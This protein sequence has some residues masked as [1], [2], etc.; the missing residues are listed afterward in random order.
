MPD[1][2]RAVAQVNHVQAAVEDRDGRR[3]LTQL[4]ADSTL[5]PGHAADAPL[6][7]ERQRASGV[8]DPVC[9][10]SK[11]QDVEGVVLNRD[12]GPRPR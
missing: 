10:L 11:V 3:G 4:A 7:I 1:S 5:A 9:V 2:G 6:T 8:I 12:R